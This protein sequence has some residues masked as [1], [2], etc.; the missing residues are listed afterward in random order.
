MLASEALS[1]KDPLA[2]GFFERF[3]LEVGHHRLTSVV[4]SDMN[5]YS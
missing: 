5:V 1:L 4:G 2:A 3:A